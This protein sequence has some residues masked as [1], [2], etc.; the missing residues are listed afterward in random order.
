MGILGQ[1]YFC[2]RKQSV[3]NKLCNNCGENLDK[4]KRSGRVKY[5]IDY[6]VNGKP[7]RESVSSFKDLN[8]Y[9]I[10]DARIA[11]SKRQIQKREK[12][13]LDMLSEYKMTFNEMTDWYVGLPSVK[14]LASYDIIKIK[15][16]I[17]NSEFGA[18]VVNDIKPV[19]LE[20]YQAKRTGD[21][22]APSTI[23]Q[24]IGKVRAMIYKAFDNDLVGGDTI[25]KFKKFKKTT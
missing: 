2:K 5:W 16:R 12:R 8:G 13:I 9:S 11:L 14:K 25:K 7:R 10:E 17:F 20:N 23:D 19:N 1:C 22:V 4:Q 6:R 21:G 24:E 15:L 18:M 3:A